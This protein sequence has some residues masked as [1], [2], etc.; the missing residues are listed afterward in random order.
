MAVILKSTECE[1]EHDFEE[2]TG[3]NYEKG[4]SLTGIYAIYPYSVLMDKKAS[5]TIEENYPLVTIDISFNGL[6]MVRIIEHDTKVINNTS[7]HIEQQRTGKGLAIFLQQV[8]TASDMGF[9]LLSCYAYGGMG[10]EAFNGYITWGKLGYTFT[11]ENDTNQDNADHPKSGIKVPI[12]SQ[13]S[14]DLYKQILKDH[15]IEFMTLE[16]LLLAEDIKCTNGTRIKSGYDFWDKFGR[17]WDGEFYLQKP[18]ENRN[19]LCRYIVRKTEN[20]KKD[21][22]VIAETLKGA[23]HPKRRLFLEGEIAKKERSIAFLSAGMKR[24]L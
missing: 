22:A 6:Q 2:L 20:L 17:A 16:A 11:G 5:I 15:H 10:Q 23:K 13:T 24:L 4:I 8:L 14:F 18:S 1:N 12:S 7:I 19:I 3:N 21:L 9:E